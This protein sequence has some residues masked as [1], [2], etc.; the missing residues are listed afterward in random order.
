MESSYHLY[1]KSD[2][3]VHPDSDEVMKT[4]HHLLED[5]I[6]ESGSTDPSLA[7]FSIALCD[8]IHEHAKKKIER[9]HAIAQTGKM[10]IRKLATKLK[11]KG[12]S[13][14]A[15]AK[16]MNISENTIRHILNPN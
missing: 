13:N 8:D 15:I 5:K 7:G 16:E 9:Q 4:L 14:A 3:R 10:T 1:I 6:K 11:D 12:Y 2:D